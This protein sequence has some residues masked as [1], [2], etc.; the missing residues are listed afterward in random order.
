MPSGSTQQ[1]WGHAASQPPSAS[2][3][4]SVSTSGGL[5]FGPAAGS[6]VGWVSLH[7][8]Q[9]PETLAELRPPDRCRYGVSLLMALTAPTALMAQQHSARVAPALYRLQRG[10]ND[11]SAPPVVFECGGGSRP[12]HVEVF[13]DPAKICLAL[14]LC[15]VWCSKVFGRHKGRYQAEAQSSHG[16]KPMVVEDSSRLA[17]LFQALF[18]TRRR[19]EAENADA[20]ANR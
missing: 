17:V 16:L 1:R 2:H 15:S 13:P 9:P 4:I 7:S 12:E 6:P 14:S 3:A 18:L 10:I 5:R 19:D 8:P 20:R 11:D